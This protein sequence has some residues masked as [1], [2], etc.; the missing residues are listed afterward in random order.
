MFKR[1]MLRVSASTLRRFKLDPEPLRLALKLST[2]NLERLSLD[3]ERLKLHPERLSLDAGACP[4][5]GRGGM[6]PFRVPALG[7]K[8]IQE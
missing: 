4:L 7:R 1:Q 3:A 8:L 5:D 6:S 2:L